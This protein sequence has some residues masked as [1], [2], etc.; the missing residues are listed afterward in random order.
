MI[1]KGAGAKHETFGA[2][3]ASRSMRIS[4]RASPRNLARIRAALMDRTPLFAKVSVLWYSR[5][6]EVRTDGWLVGLGMSYWVES[7]DVVL[8][9]EER[10]RSTGMWLVVDINHCF[11]AAALGCE[12]STRKMSV[13]ARR[14]VLVRPVQH[15]R[16]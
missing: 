1:R 7:L 16:G 13:R 11:S 3:Q 15:L 8:F 12:M 5:H 4:A 14:L 10:M 2:E 6:L 9:E